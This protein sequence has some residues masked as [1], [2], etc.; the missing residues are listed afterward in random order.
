MFWGEHQNS[1]DEKGRVTI[2]ASWRPRLADGFFLCPG[3]DSCLFLLPMERWLQV[4]QKLAEASLGSA[5][6]EK[7]QRH[8]GSGSE[9]MLDRQ[10]RVL[11][12]PKLRDRAGLSG[13]VLL[14]GAFNRIEVWNPETKERYDEGNLT[15]QR[16]REAFRALVIRL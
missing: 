5:D 11:I 7:L 9:M 14:C 15:D 1:L 6:A 4:Q 16:L 10:G 3:L 2:P 12:P 8:F 13:E